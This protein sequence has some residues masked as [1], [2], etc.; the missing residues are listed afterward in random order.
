M[1]DFGM[2]TIGDVLLF[3]IRKRPGRTEAELAEAIFGE[4]GYQQRVNEDC[5]LLERQ[6]YVERVGTGGPGDPFRYFPV[7]N[8]LDTET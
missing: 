5:K 6:G 4:H 2:T 3:L 1:G 8:E 7:A